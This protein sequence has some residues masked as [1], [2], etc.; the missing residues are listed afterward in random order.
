[1]GSQAASFADSAAVAKVHV[2]LD[3]QSCSPRSLLRTSAFEDYKGLL[4][5]IR[6][7]YHS[8]AKRPVTL[9]QLG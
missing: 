7:P 5:C 8:S 3:R 1:M 6:Y 2:H 9:V 4:S